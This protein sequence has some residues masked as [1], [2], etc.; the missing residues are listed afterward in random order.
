MH[1]GIGDIACPVLSAKYSCVVMARSAAPCDEIARP[2]ENSAQ[3]G[4]RLSPRR[5]WG[6]SP[7]SFAKMR[8]VKHLYI[9]APKGPI[10]RSPRGIGFV[11]RSV[12]RGR[13]PV[14]GRA[15]HGT[16]STGRCP[17]LPRGRPGPPRTVYKVYRRAARRKA[18]D[19]A[20]VIANVLDSIGGPLTSGPGPVRLYDSSMWNG[21]IS[22]GDPYIVRRIS[23]HR[24]SGPQA[25]RG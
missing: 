10:L 20:F 24:P 23:R 1:H 16:R 25:E 18:V 17:G 9:A 5:G 7:S 13:C 12:G 21:A 3:A 2:P 15:P 19:H 11:P 22:P 8:G 14:V 4:P 6:S